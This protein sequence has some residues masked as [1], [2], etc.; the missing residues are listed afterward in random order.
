MNVKKGE[1]ADNKKES[2]TTTNRVPGLIEP[3][4]LYTFREVAIR[5]TF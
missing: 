3:D 2:A 1:P 4:S 5:Q